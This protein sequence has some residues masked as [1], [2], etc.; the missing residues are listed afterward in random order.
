MF[1]S[2]LQS[3]TNPSKTPWFLTTLICSRA[4]M[5]WQ[6]NNSLQHKMKT[7]PPSL[8]TNIA[9]RAGD[10][11]HFYF[12]DHVL[13]TRTMSTDLWGSFFRKWLNRRL[14]TESVCWQRQHQDRL[15]QLYSTSHI[16]GWYWSMV[17]LSATNGKLRVQQC[18]LTP[19][20]HLTQHILYI[21]LQQTVANDTKQPLG[22]TLCQNKGIPSHMRAPHKTKIQPA[23]ERW[24]LID[25][26][27]RATTERPIGCTKDGLL[28]FAND[29]KL[30][31]KCQN[32]T[33]TA[34]STKTC[35]SQSQ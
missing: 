23:L 15:Q 18:S 25:I 9:T 34:K 24:Q 5:N 31:P 6:Y 12:H 13:W 17:L 3:G 10:L 19:R 16:W 32:C 35:C 29:N 7:T 2:P 14:A 4:T 26:P 8:I 28:S 27:M 1:Y 21:W 20:E 30:S 22:W 11:G 33:T